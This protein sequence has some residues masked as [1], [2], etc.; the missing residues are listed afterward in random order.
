MIRSQS[1]PRQEVSDM[2]R[3]LFGLFAVFPFFRIGV[4]VAN[5]Q[6]LGRHPSFQVL[7]K[8]FRTIAIPLL[9]RFWSISLCILSGPGLFPFFS[10]LRAVLSSSLVKGSSKILGFIRSFSF[11]LRRPM[12]L[13]SRSVFLLLLLTE[14]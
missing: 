4:I 5:F 6:A 10:C 13:R 3:K 2:G 14:A 1:F 8:R 11:V 12:R 9:P 7:L